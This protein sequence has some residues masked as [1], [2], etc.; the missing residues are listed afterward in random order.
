MAL[1]DAQVNRLQGFD[2]SVF[3][4][5]AK[6]GFADDASRYLSGLLNVLSP[7][8]EEDPFE[9][10]A[11]QENANHQTGQQEVRRKKSMVSNTVIKSTP[12]EALVSEASTFLSTA[13]SASAL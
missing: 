8:N 3:D 12:T 13:R 6:K 1:L 10:L 2:L 11:R 7:S 4:V 5:P 9:V